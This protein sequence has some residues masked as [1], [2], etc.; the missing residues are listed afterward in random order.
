[1]LLPLYYGWEHICDKSLEEVCFEDYLKEPYKGF[2]ANP[3]TETMELA[4]L[5]QMSSIPQLENWGK[6]LNNLITIY[7]TIVNILL[8][9][10]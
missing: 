2:E 8:I 9:N 3:A 7:E 10:K 6:K 4:L 5:L 1:M